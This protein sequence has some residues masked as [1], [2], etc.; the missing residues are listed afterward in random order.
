MCKLYGRLCHS[1][2]VDSVNQKKKRETQ[3]SYAER[4]LC[5]QFSPD[6][7]DQLNKNSCSDPAECNSSSCVE[8][9]IPFNEHS[10]LM[11]QYSHHLHRRKTLLLCSAIIWKVQNVV[12]FGMRRKRYVNV[13]AWKR[14]NTHYLVRRFSTSDDSQYKR[15]GSVRW[16]HAQKSSTDLLCGGKWHAL[17]P[18]QSVWVEFVVCLR[19]FS[20]ILRMHYRLSWQ[21]PNTMNWISMWCGCWWKFTACRIL[22]DSPHSTLI[23]LI[24]NIRTWYEFIDTKVTTDSTNALT[25]QRLVYR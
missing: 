5:E 25:P 7:S 3:T 24:Y 12:C 16:R 17:S 2:L 23:E 21:F 8:Q 1:D 15:T 4:S 14:T 9:A 18:L 6:E 19:M 20:I 22:Y 10:H 13:R 11:V